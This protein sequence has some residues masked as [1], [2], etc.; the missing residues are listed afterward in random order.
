[1]SSSTRRDLGGRRLGRSG[2]HLSE[3]GLGTYG[4]GSI[5]E[6]TACDLLD[7]ALE[8]GIAVVDTADTYGQGRSESI[9]GAW[10]RG[11]PRDSVVISTKGGNAT[12]PGRNQR[13]ASRAHLVP[14]LEASLRRLG[15]D[16]VDLY[17]VHAYDA[18]TE[19][20]E[21]M[22]TLDDLVRAGKV[23][24]LGASRIAAWQLCR[25]LWVSEKVGTARFESVQVSYSLIDRSEE[26]EMFPL[27]AAE[28]VGLITYWPLAGGILTGKYSAAGAY[29]PNARVFSQ[30][31]FAARL[32]TA[33]LAAAAE[34]S[35]LA[36]Q[37]GCTPGQLALAW[38]LRRPDIACV[39]SGATSVAQLRDNLGALQ[40]SAPD[41]A[42]DSLDRVSSRF[43]RTGLREVEN[44]P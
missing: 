29:P 4:F 40:V 35:A 37:L 19:I 6:R 33:R 3:L 17:Q 5:D 28:R 21:T 41:G 43:T 18:E 11:K 12:G 14:A 9:I 26:R 22:R 8:A 42:W 30:P 1:M 15:T 7:H 25:S 36:G 34:V 27:C 20:E 16:H 13:G 2:L 23:R 31:E 38:V 39:L 44:S 10:L 32:T 24:Y